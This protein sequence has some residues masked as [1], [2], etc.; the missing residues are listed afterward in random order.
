MYYCKS[1]YLPVVVSLYAQDWKLT[2]MIM[3]VVQSIHLCIKR[4]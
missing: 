4:N 2:E 3:A 1:S